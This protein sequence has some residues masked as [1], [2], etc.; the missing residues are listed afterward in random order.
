MDSLLEFH[1][2]IDLFIVYI[3]ACFCWIILY[4][5]LYGKSRTVGRLIK[6]VDRL[7]GRPLRSF[8]LASKSGL[9][10]FVLGMGITQGR[11]FGSTGRSKSFLKA[12]SIIRF[13][14]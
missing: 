8:V 2:V 13:T 11:S 5:Y 4:L 7:L 3:M 12:V 1:N 10:H 14:S 9:F 6:N